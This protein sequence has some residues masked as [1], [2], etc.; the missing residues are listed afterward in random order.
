VARARSAYPHDVILLDGI[1]SGIFRVA[2]FDHGF[3]ALGIGEVYLTPGSE[4]HI[5]PHAAFVR[6]EEYT[7]PAA[8]AERRRAEGLLRVYRVAS[9]RLTDIT[10]GYVW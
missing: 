9:G 6:V 5:R 10:A 4:R 2:V 1:D 3:A 7:L 8:L